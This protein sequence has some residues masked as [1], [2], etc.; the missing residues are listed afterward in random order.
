M[1]K[2]NINPL[3][4]SIR[5][6]FGNVVFYNRHGNTYIRRHVMPRN[7]RTMVQQLNRYAFAEAVRLWQAM[8]ADERYRFIRKARNLNMSGYNLFI[9][10][11]MKKSEHIPASLHKIKH[12][13]FSQ[14][15]FSFGNPFIAVPY[16][17]KRL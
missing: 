12:S 17:N 7:P 3:L 4:K 16:Y 15:R 14:L 9:S 6:R 1:A 13:S 5:G 10:E 2:A 8:P 11:Y